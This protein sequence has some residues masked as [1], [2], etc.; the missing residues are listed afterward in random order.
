MRL[1]LIGLGAMLAGAAACQDTITA[2]IAPYRVPCNDLPPSAMCW[3]FTDDGAEPRKE[4]FLFRNGLEY[5]WGEELRVRYHRPEEDNDAPCGR[6]LGRSCLAL[7]EVV[8]RTTVAA[9]T[10]FAL[11]LPALS[12]PPWFEATAT[13]LTFSEA[14]VE[15]ACEPAI[16]QQVLARGNAA[17]EVQFE[18]T[19]DLAVPLRV[20]A[21][22]P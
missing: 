3:L 19:G 1:A 2:T 21:T 6:F 8:S 5:N 11:A 12:G 22:T 15:T 16:C 9:G 17:F 10:R 18:M 14:T 13:G 4:Y 20:L 7:D